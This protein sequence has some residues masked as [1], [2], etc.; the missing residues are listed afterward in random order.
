ML[1]TFSFL[2]ITLSYLSRTYDVLVE[3]ANSM[4]SWYSAGYKSLQPASSQTSGTCLHGQ[5][6]T[7]IFMRSRVAFRSIAM[8]GSSWALCARPWT[9]CCGT[10][11]SI[12]HLIG[13]LNVGWQRFYLAHA[14]LTEGWKY[15]RALV[16]V[17]RCNFIGFDRWLN[18][19]VFM[20]GRLLLQ[21]LFLLMVTGFVRSFFFSG[22]RLFRE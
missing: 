3:Y 13:S 14:N 22:T 8:C 12:F 2:L 6:L 7:R 18:D 1:H 21:R 19:R 20:D 10:H 9:M 5:W 11:V 17:R 15:E 4:K 16:G